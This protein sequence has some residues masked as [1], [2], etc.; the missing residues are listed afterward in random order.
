MTDAVTFIE[1]DKFG[2]V[3]V[4]RSETSTSPGGTVGAAT[5][6][7]L[8]PSGDLLFNISAPKDALNPVAWFA[9][10]PSGNFFITG[11]RLFIPP[12]FTTMY[13]FVN[14]YSPAGTL[15]WSKLFINATIGRVVPNLAAGIALVE[16]MNAT[17]NF[18]VILNITNGKIISSM[19]LSNVVTSDN[20]LQPVPASVSNSKGHYCGVL[21]STSSSVP[22]RFVQLDSTGSIVWTLNVSGVFLGN[23]HQVLIDESDNCIFIGETIG[24]FTIGSLSEPSYEIRPDFLVRVNSLGEPLYI[25]VF[26][27]DLIGGIT[28]ASFNPVFSDCWISG[29]GLEGPLTLARLDSNDNI[30]DIFL[31]SPIEATNVPSFKITF[32]GADIIE[33]AFTIGTTNESW[34]GVPII[35]PSPSAA[36]PFPQKTVVFQLNLSTSSPATCN[37]TSA[38][39]CA[40]NAKCCYLYNGQTACFS[41]STYNCFSGTHQLCE[42]GSLTCGNTTNCYNPTQ[43]SC[44]GNFL[45]PV[46]TTLCGEQSCYAPSQYTCFEGYFLCPIGALKCGIACYNP[47]FYS[48]NSKN[49]LIPVQSR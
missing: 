10:A 46:G 22:T 5:I 14:A 15:L 43:S 31:G 36:E 1:T 27:L 41:Q 39:L 48:C 44:I 33:G 18:A 47:N 49:Q 24:L 8:N 30:A 11:D 29:V 19:T 4:V 17:E 28:C 26:D 34:F 42:V 21:F 9:V 23:I 32:Y 16:G 35:V 45:C 6:F 3:Y 7:K 25:R 13:G 37:T 40:Q 12:D 20:A 38:S 2:N